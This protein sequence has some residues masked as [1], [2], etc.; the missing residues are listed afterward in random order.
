[1]KKPNDDGRPVVLLSF[2]GSVPHSQ[3]LNRESAEKYIT[4]D[5]FLARVRA[6]ALRAEYGNPRQ[7]PTES[8]EDFLRR[9][10]SIDEGNTCGKFSD[11]RIEADKV[12][13]IFH[14]NDSA[15]KTLSVNQPKL[16]FGMRSLSSADGHLKHIVSF[17][18]IPGPDED[19]NVQKD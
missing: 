14:V 4:N 13:G 6:G 9:A 15:T 2:D 19:K 12:I 3:A 16:R 18:F 11:V 10:A 7:R 1:M 17:D 5:V 8:T